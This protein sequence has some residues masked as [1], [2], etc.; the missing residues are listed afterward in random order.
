[1]SSESSEVSPGKWGGEGIRRK[2]RVP[3]KKPTG[4]KVQR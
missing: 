1:M 4:G 3:G 2:N